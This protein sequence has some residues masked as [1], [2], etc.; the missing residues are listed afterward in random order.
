MSPAATDIS[1]TPPS[2]LSPTTFVLPDLVSDCPYPL[3]INP[4]FHDVAPASEQW[5][6][7]GAHLVE[8]AITKF[9]GVKA[10]GL[11]GVC[12]PNADALHLRVCSDF[13]NWT[14]DTDDW[15]E[16][17]S[18]EGVLSMRDCCVGVCRDPIDFQTGKFGAQM[19]RSR[20]FFSRFIQ[21][22][23]PRCTE[24][25]IRAMDLS[26]IAVAKQV[27]DRAKG[28]IPD[29]DSYITLRRGTSILAGA[30]AL[31]EYAARIDLPDE[32]LSHP[33]IVAMEDATN[34]Y[35]SWHND[36]FSYN[37]E[38][39]RGDPHNL[40]DV[41]MHDKGLDLQ[42]AMDYAVGLCK[43][44][45]QRFED[46]RGMLPS[47]GKE[48]D[49]QVAIYVQG[50]QDWNVGSLHWHLAISE[51]YFGKEAP[52]VAQTRIVQLLPKRPN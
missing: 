41:L 10:G 9:K 51:R 3:R 5:L 18:V 46:N 16:E 49:Q 20:A 23:G 48:L 12:Y 19:R 28:H 37:I 27:E 38:Q 4:H 13:L 33:A 25:F 11:A 30:F 22:G 43:G 21:T 2:E 42:G 44:A 29:L 34:D 6:I 52:Q 24:R 50:L 14:F 47:W 31:V 36:I 17:F 32:V 45:I 39:S 7:E 40:I 35:V 1:S 26:F 8:P 15:L